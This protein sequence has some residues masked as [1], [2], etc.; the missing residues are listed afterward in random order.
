MALLFILLLWSRF[1]HLLIVSRFF[2]SGVGLL[3]GFLSPSSP[4]PCLVFVCVPPFCVWFVSSPPCFLLSSLSLRRWGN[5]NPLWGVWV[6]PCVSS[7]R[8]R[9]PTSTRTLT[10]APTPWPRPALAF[11]FFSFSPSSSLVFL[12]LVFLGLSWWCCVSSWFVSGGGSLHAF[13][14]NPNALV[15]RGGRT[16]HP[17]P[18][19]GLLSRLLF[20]DWVRTGVPYIFGKMYRAGLTPPTPFLSNAVKYSPGRGWGWPREGNRTVTLRLLVFPPSRRGNAVR[21]FHFVFLLCLVRCLL[22]F[23]YRSSLLRVVV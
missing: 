11:F 15:A 19:L 16:R 3:S 7:S 2:V 10:S 8:T 6:S 20:W 4:D 5:P 17:S 9:S 18:Q 22:S 23:F 1:C 12:V 14:D 13:L 21:F